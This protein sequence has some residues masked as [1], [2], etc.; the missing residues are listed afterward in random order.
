MSITLVTELA[1]NGAAERWMHLKP[2]AGKFYRA[3]NGKSKI[4]ARRIVS[5][6][7]RRAIC[8]EPL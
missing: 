8:V 2:E 6:S 5:R 7:S 1:S 4:R 3:N